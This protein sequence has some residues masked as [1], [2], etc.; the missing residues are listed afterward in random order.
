MARRAGLKRATINRILTGSR[1]VWPETC[2]GIA[3]AF[4]YAPEDVFKMAGI[5]PKGKAANSILANRILEIFDTL[6]PE[7]QEELVYIALG[8]RERG[9]SKHVIPTATEGNIG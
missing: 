6:P 4:G 8:L 9:K 7:Y 5:L 2:I 3:K 1:G